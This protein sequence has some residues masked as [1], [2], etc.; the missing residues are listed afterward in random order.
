MD[1]PKTDLL[2]RIT[3]LMNRTAHLE[4]RLAETEA[5][6]IEANET[7]RAR[8]KKAWYSRVHWFNV[9]ALLAAIIT[10]LQ[11]SK[12]LSTEILTVLA[13]V[14]PIGNLILRQLTTQPIVWDGTTTEGTGTDANP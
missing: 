6:L 14:V 12:L 10:A 9:M 11:S 1:D 2:N 13:T 4:E 5:A 7:I 3:F 8:G